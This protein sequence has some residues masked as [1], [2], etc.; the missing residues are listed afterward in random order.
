[1]NSSNDEG[2]QIQKTD[3]LVV[4]PPTPP[5]SELFITP[6]GQQIISSTTIPKDLVNNKRN[7][8]VLESD[9]PMKSLKKSDDW[10]KEQIKPS[11]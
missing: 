7:M 6:I 1:M 2:S 8:I 5:S 9:N 4:E 3:K 10:S 11:S